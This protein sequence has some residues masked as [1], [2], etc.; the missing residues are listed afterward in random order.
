MA[1]LDAV[2]PGA[3]VRTSDGVDL[4]ALR[5]R[6]RCIGAREAAWRLRWQP[7]EPAAL[8]SGGRPARHAR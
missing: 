3:G 1:D 8:Q 5:R 2:R 4:V 6:E 7:E